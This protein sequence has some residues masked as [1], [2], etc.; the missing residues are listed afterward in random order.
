V[1]IGTAGH[2]DHG[3][4]ALVRA[5]TG[6]DTDRLPE[7]KRRGITIDL[8]FAPLDL[9]NVGVAGVVDVPGHEAFVR[10]MLAGATGID[11]ALLIVAADE[12]VMPQT[13]E[14]VAILE[15]LGIRGGVVAL[16]KHDLV[17]DDDW[18]E[19]V[20]L[21][22]A[23]LL[24]GT[25]LADAAVIP[26]SVVT[27]AGLPEL[28]AALA[29]AA[30]ATAPRPDDDVFRM[31]IDRVF[32]MR[33]TGTV[34]TG[35]V[36]SGSIVRDQTV[37]IMPGERS[38][39]VRGLQAHG[40]PLDRAHPGMRLAVALAGIDHDAVAR[41]AVLVA[42]TGWHPTRVL[43]ADV[44][45]LANTVVSLSPRATVRFHLGTTE[46]GARIVTAGGPLMAGDTKAARVVLDA[47]IIARAGDRFVIRGGSPI[48]TIGGGVVV[49][50]HPTHR[51]ARPWSGP[52]DSGSDRLTLALREAGGQGLEVSQLAVRIGAPPREVAASVDER[53]GDVV[54]IGG[55]IFDAG[56]RD[57]VRSEL[58]RLVEN[59]HA[60]HPLDMGAALQTVRAQLTGRPELV[61]DAIRAVTE[62]GGVE[63]D[64]GLIR[65]AGWAPRL[66]PGQESVKASL[67]V[68]LRSAGAE[69]PSV[70]E[71]E[72]Q[73]GTDVPDL[74]RILER[75]GV[76]VSVESDRYYHQ[77][78][79]GA[80]VDRLRAGL[81]GGREYSPGELRDVIGLS[82][83]FLIPFLEYCDK[84]GITERRPGGRV[85]HGT[86]DA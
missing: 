5:L 33:G 86:L 28:R 45:L 20:R 23:E 44:S 22:L 46:V 10:T 75:E 24:E 65:Q 18:L 11:L 16:T 66:T 7:E 69:P 25:A 84:R 59:H 60:D 67:V 19:L 32:T 52:H 80:L 57:L 27:G 35:T 17:V 49:D 58:V 70:G 30:A 68:S 50:P 51:R 6:V 79:L 12:G 56:V 3:K 39:R 26:T 34:V 72:T 9:P 71:L 48:G 62:E 1:I 41:G 63:V 8:G 53:N 4:T 54:R 82:R 38:V 36:W 83:K 13:R 2:I 43:R 81:E 78:A 21:D 64:S 31:P 73:F 55:R 85:L 15:L 40:A 14:H 42:D 74:I 37:T 61:D 29:S 77:E 47:E 76:V